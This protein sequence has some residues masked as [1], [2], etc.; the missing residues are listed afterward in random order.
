MKDWNLPQ[1]DGHTQ[2]IPKKEGQRKLSLST[3]GLDQSHLQVDG[4]T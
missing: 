2:V 4:P 3:Y 1:V